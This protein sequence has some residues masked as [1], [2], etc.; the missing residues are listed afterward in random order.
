LFQFISL[1]F[2][3]FSVDFALKVVKWTENQMIK[4]QLWDIAGKIATAR[5]LISKA[6]P[7]YATIALH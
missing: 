2:L 6:M 1:T 4:L 5:I 3:S 7:F